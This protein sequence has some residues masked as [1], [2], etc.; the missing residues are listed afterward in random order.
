MVF[1]P[2]EVYWWLAVLIFVQLEKFSPSSQRQRTCKDAKLSKSSV[3]VD[4]STWNVVEAK[5]L[6]GVTE[7]DA[8]G[9]SLLTSTVIEVSPMAP[10]VSFT[11]SVIFFEPL[12][13][14]WWLA[15]LVVDQFVKISL[16]SHFHRTCNCDI[17]SISS[18]ELEASTWKKVSQLPLLG[19]TVNE[20]IG[21]WFETWTVSFEDT[22]APS[23]SFTS[24]VITLPPRE[25]Y[26]WLAVLLVVQL[27]KFPPSSHCQRT[28]SCE[29]LSKSSVDADASTWKVVNTDPLNGVTVN[30]AV[31][32][33]LLTVTGLVVEP[34]A[35][36]I[37]FTSSVMVFE[38]FES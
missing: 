26:W 24:R 8:F 1:V 35:P 4:A 6:S 33:P 5:P 30:E 16:S 11:S 31:G 12:D 27:V 21:D 15:V 38:S 23:V 9:A 25:A 14:Y 13:E 17:S 10:S 32:A 22:K 2:L 19:V 7:K 29:T 36:L 18:V 37:S 3:H 28:S 20:A 34:T